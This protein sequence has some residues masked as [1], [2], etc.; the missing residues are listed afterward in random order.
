MG[1][2]IL[3]PQRSFDDKAASTVYDML[4]MDKI[5]LVEAISHGDKIGMIYTILVD[6]QPD[7]MLQQNEKWAKRLGKA[8]VF[9]KKITGCNVQL[10]ATLVLLGVIDPTRGIEPPGEKIR[11]FL[12]IGMAIFRLCIA[13]DWIKEEPPTFE[14][15]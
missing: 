7:N 13:T 2:L 15:R 11:F 14:I 5:P 8:E 10:S 12:C 9:P 1:P 3:P 4:A 6:L